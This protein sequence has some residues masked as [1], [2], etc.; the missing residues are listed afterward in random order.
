[1]VLEL[2]EP[3]LPGIVHG[4]PC[5]ADDTV[6][7]RQRRVGSLWEVLEPLREARPQRICEGEIAP[8]HRGSTRERE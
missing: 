5:G 3:L 6:D 7:C 2:R 8:A 1:M 4:E